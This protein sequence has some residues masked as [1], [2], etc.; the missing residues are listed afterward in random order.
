MRPP[1]FPFKE[2]D[3]LADQSAVES[4]SEMMRGGQ[5]QGCPLLTNPIC[6]PLAASLC[7]RYVSPH[8]QVCSGSMIS[9]DELVQPASSRM[10]D[11][12][13]F[14]PSPS[15]KARDTEPNDRCPCRTVRLRESV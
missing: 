7:E 5:V 1:L 4:G 15:L 10:F 8:Q 9:A 14:P 13:R 11:I 3:L 12:A 2:R 6:T